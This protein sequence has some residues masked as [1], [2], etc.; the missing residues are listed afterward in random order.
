MKGK[1]ISHLDFHSQVFEKLMIYSDQESDTLPA[2]NLKNEDS[3]PNQRLDVIDLRKKPWGSVY[4]EPQTTLKVQKLAPSWT[5]IDPDSQ[6][7][8]KKGA[9]T[10]T[11][12]PYP[13]GQVDFDPQ[14]SQQKW[15]A[16]ES[17]WSAQFDDTLEREGS[18]YWASEEGMIKPMPS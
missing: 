9:S 7:A 16:N 12:T 15:D 17:R 10:D 4:V 1:F 11:E 6:M 2:I 18:D 5:I 8:E 13:Q 3:D 14:S